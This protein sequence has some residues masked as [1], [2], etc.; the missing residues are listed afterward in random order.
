MHPWCCHKPNAP[1]GGDDGKM[2]TAGGGDDDDVDGVEEMVVCGVI[3]VVAVVAMGLRWWGDHDGG[4]SVVFGDGEGRSGGEAKVGQPWMVL[5]AVVRSE[6]DRRFNI[7][8]G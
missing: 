7:V 1:Y 3:R 6:G 4:G 8:Q 2:V 5:M